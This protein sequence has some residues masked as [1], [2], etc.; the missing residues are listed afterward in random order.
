MNLD[1]FIHHLHYDTDRARPPDWET[2]WEDAP[3]SYKLYRG[4]PEVPLSPEVPLTLE[5]RQKPGKT[6]LREIGHFLWYA[7]GLTQVCQSILPFDSEHQAVSSMLF[8]RR[9]IPSGGG[10][11]PNELYIYLKLEDLPAGVY[12]YDAAHHRLVLLREGHF[13]SYLARALGS[14]CDVSAC[15]GMVFVSTLFWK[16]FFKYHNFGYRLQGLDAGVLIGQLLEV[17]KRFGVSSGVYFQFLDRAVNHLLGLSE[18]EESVYAVIPLSSDP[19][20]AWFA[21]RGDGDAMVSAAELCRELPAVWH[22]HYVRSQRIRGY[23]MLVRMNEASL[24][25]SPRS[26]RRIGKEWTADDAGEGPTVKLSP[27]RRLSYDLAAVCKKRYSP[28]MD[29]VTGRVSEPNLAALL[30]EAAE[31]YGYRN[32]LDGNCEDPAPRVILYC[33]LYG[34]EGIPDGAYRYDS[35]RHVL[36][37]VR[38]GDHRLW[39]QQGMSL[40][41]VNLYQVPLCLHVAGDKDHLHSALGYRGYRVQQMEAGMLVQRLLLAAFALG[42]GGH[43]LLGYDVSLCDEVYHMARQG[44]TSLIQVPVGPYRD[45]PRLSGGLHG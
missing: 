9:F 40:D 6:G 44:R 28:E 22:R 23:P 43:P 42:M 14:R 34:V 8:K 25:E 31:S 32:D 2:D 19:D 11:Y 24:M 36:S 37:Q 17:A 29:F 18:W 21:N 4:L 41:N 39:L 30:R 3:L 33:C 45:R 5:G 10:L 15:F 27:V 7:F 16:N 35:V 12:H 38:P 1:A 26:F 13:D 20:I